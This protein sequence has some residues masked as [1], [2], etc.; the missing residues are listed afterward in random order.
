MPAFLPDLSRQVS[1]LFES[2]RKLQIAVDKK[3]TAVIDS[4]AGVGSLR[5][6]GGTATSAAAGDHTHA[7]P[8]VWTAYTPAWQLLTVGNATYPY[9]RWTRWG[10]TVTVQQ[11]F[12]FGTTTTVQGIFYP[13]LPVLPLGGAT[14]ALFTGAATAYCNNVFYG[15]T[16]VNGAYFIFN[17]ARATTTLPNTWV[18]GSAI[19]WEL[20][21]EV[22]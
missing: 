16:F 18:T 15:G 10:Q 9:S 7:A 14:S 3:Y 8:G 5:T 1:E 6:L 17:N 19:W 22:A 4:A 2:A 11:R 21:Y 12:A 13:S 20:T